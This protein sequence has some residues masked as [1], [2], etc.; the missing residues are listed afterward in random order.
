M[1]IYQ[2]VTDIAYVGA[3]RY[4][5]YVAK[6]LKLHLACGHEQYRKASQ[7][8]PLKAKCRDCERT[9]SSVRSYRR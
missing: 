7:G 8:V 5:G 2:R 1:T 4:T 6:S 3:C 9:P